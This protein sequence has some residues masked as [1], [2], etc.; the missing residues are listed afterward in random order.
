MRTNAHDHGG[1]ILGGPPFAAAVF[2]ADFHVSQIDCHTRAI[3]IAAG[4]LGRSGCFVAA[5]KPQGNH[6]PLHPGRRHFVVV[7]IEKRLTGVDHGDV[8][9]SVAVVIQDSEAPAIRG[10][11]QTREA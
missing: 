11:I 4:V 6:S 5:D 7:E 1:R 9:P 2:P 8:L 10:N 3:A